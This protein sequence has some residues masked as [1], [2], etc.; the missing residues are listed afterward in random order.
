MAEQ[1]TIVHAGDI[2]AAGPV[3]GTFVGRLVYYAYHDNEVYVLVRSADSVCIEA[4]ITAPTDSI[5]A[6]AI[7]G[8]YLCLEGAIAV[9]S[10]TSS[11][12]G[13]RFM[14]TTH[15]HDHVSFIL[16][17]SQIQ[18]DI[19]ASRVT[20][21]TIPFTPFNEI[22][23]FKKF[24]VVGWLASVERRSTAFGDIMSGVI[25]DGTSSI[26]FFVPNTTVKSMQ[27]TDAS[28]DHLNIN[29]NKPVVVVNAFCRPSTFQK[30]FNYVLEASM[31]SLFTNDVDSFLKPD[32]VSEVQLWNLKDGV[33]HRPHLQVLPR[34]YDCIVEAFPLSSYDSFPGSN[35]VIAG[36]I[37]NISTYGQQPLAE[38]R[39]PRWSP[40]GSAHLC[41]LMG[42]KV[43]CKQCNGTVSQPGA[44]YTFLLTISQPNQSPLTLRAYE[45]CGK[46][47]TGHDTS[48]LYLTS[49]SKLSNDARRAHNTKLITSVLGRR[50]IVGV[51]RK[52][53]GTAGNATMLMFAD[54]SAPANTAEPAPIATP[55]P[56]AKRMRRT[57]V[58]DD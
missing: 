39:C 7:R 47:I 35:L 41:S 20:D 43:Y 53:P 28:C 26:E 3:A 24:N 33:T 42:N 38:Y 9:E 36:T 4:I 31:Y 23:L 50:V 19:P 58:L 1:E 45:G 14:L 56:V 12:S 13:H 2:N 21:V 25:V 52:D 11:V 6:D 51:W 30:R 17:D 44:A 48:L 37:L 40:G 5:L 55:P 49:I 8:R 10:S 18:A 34:D 29:K 46:P 16:K 57:V 54:E 32:V 27:D 22:R 15:G